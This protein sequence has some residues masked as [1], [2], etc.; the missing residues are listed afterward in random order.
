MKQLAWGAKV[1]PE[2]RKKL[3]SI[4]D[5]FGWF[6]LHANW[7]MACIAFESGETFS[8]SIKNMAGSGATGLIQ[9]MPTTARGLGTSTADLAAMTAEEQLDYVR[10]YFK[11]YSLKIGSLSDMYMAI[12]LPKYVGRSD[13][14]I[15][16][17]R[18]T[19]AYRQN[20]GLDSNSDGTITKGEASR[21]VLEK[22]IKGNKPPH[23]SD[24]MC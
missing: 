9:F 7:L 21:K 6:D 2:F 24:F 5:G 23:V 20:A 15:L 18:G 3:K 8:P 14:A 10:R 22:L 13:D 1:S 16:F 17:T 11:P 19:I 12:L 4:C